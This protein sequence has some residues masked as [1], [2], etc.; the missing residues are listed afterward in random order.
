[1]RFWVK[2]FISAERRLPEFVKKWL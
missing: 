1:M 2:C